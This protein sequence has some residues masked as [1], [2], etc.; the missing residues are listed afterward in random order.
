MTNGSPPASE[1]AAASGDGAEHRRGEADGLRLVLAHGRGDPV[2]ERRE[3]VRPRLE[4]VLVE[5][6]ARA[7]AGA[8]D[9]VALE[10]GAPRGLAKL[11]VAHARRAAHAGP[12]RKRQEPSPPRASRRRTRPRS[13]RRSRRRAARGSRRT[14]PVERRCP[15]T[16][17]LAKPARANNLRLIGAFR[18]A[19][20]ASARLGRPQAALQVVE[21]EPGGRRGPVVAAIACRRATAKTLP[22]QLGASSCVTRALVAPERGS[23]RRAA[24]APRVR[25]GPRAARRPPTEPT[26]SPSSGNH[27]GRLDLR[28]DLDEIGERPR[29]LHRRR[30]YQRGF[31][32]DDSPPSA[33]AQV[34]RRPGHPS[35]GD[36][37]VLR[38]PLVR[39]ARLP[40]AVAL[41]LRPPRATR[42][43]SSSAS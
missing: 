11:S 22:R 16:T 27:G 43:T 18:C 32:R 33:R 8:Q 30:G 4:A 35:R 24:L 15:R 36:G 42:R 13:R 39:A 20:G 29:S 6:V 5:V 41:G 34:L 12:A 25:G 3:D 31:A 14:A 40:H 19:A 23:R 2:T 17:P 7:L 21:D 26:S 28:R 1:A 10:V 37:R 38:A 9:E